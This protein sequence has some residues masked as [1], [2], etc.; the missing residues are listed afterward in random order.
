[1]S[2]IEDSSGTE[3]ATNVSIRE[4]WWWMRGWFT[5]GKNDHVCFT[6]GII[7]PTEVQRSP[8]SWLFLFSQCPLR[9]Y[10]FLLLH[11]CFCYLFIFQLCVTIY[12]RSL[13]LDKALCV[14]EWIFLTALTLSALCMRSSI[15]QSDKSSE[16]KERD[17]ISMAGQWWIR[18]LKCSRGKQTHS[19]PQWEVIYVSGHFCANLLH[20]DG[21]KRAEDVSF[22]FP[23]FLKISAFLVSLCWFQHM[24]SLL[25]YFSTCLCKSSAFP[26]SLII[27]AP[28]ALPKS[29]NPDDKQPRQQLK[30]TKRPGKRLSPR[31]PCLSDTGPPLLTS[32]NPHYCVVGGK[33][34]DG[35]RSVQSNF[36]WF[37]G[38]IGFLGHKKSLF[39]GYLLWTA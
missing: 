34:V 38:T 13:F 24:A 18:I 33:G 12:S 36:V 23:S 26:P 31:R 5:N 27:H 3:K 9:H 22:Y 2:E 14:V 37:R 1:M 4:N 28:I 16:R 25:G 32:I 11:S 20:K 10:S 17:S 21:A 6:A 39:W 19:T 35:G 15:K 8:P 7:W 30:G 29:V